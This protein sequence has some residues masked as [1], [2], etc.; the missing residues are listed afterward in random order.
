M[1]YSS[2]LTIVIL[3]F[4][5]CNGITNQ[6]D[7]NF[8]TKQASNID[9]KEKS[10][11]DTAQRNQDSIQY[12]IK[13]DKQ[14]YSITES[15]VVTIVA[16]NISP[17]EIKIWIDGGDYPVGTE[18]NLLNAKGESIVLQH[19]SYMSSQAYSL[20]EV[21]NLKTTIPPKQEFKK[22]YN[23]LSIVQLK[24]S[25]TK[26]TYEVRYNNAAPIKFEIK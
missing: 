2:A 20:E 3:G 7:S 22:E 6:N 26:G 25:L 12:E 14:I 13:L 19:W 24:K 5:G 17:K 9:D 11:I 10:R 8:S 18:L 21:E 15:I 23:L 16:K 1:K 4:W